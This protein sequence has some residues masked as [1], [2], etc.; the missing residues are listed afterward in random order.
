MT[1]PSMSEQLQS[2]SAPV[3]SKAVEHIGND[4]HGQLYTLKVKE[5]LDRLFDVSMKFMRM[6]IL[7]TREELAQACFDLLIA[8]EYRENVHFR[9]TVYFGKGEYLRYSEDPLKCGVFITTI[10]RPPNPQTETGI[11]ACISTW[12]RIDDRGFPPRI[13]L[14]ANYNNSRLASVEAHMNGYDSGILLNTAG[15]VAESYGSCLFMVRKG[16]V[17][18]PS[19]TSGILES[20]TR[21]SVIELFREE[22]GLEVVERDVDRNRALF[23]G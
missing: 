4:E 23:G 15:K 22:M 11:T 6:G 3:S 7:W 8:C 18:T 20:I 17:V 19:T 2:C 5:H 13:K 10:S 9:P 16:R 14:G 12:L 21:D 1:Q